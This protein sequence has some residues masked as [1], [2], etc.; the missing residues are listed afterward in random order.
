[1]LIAHGSSGH[2]EGTTQSAVAD[3]TV[4]VRDAANQQ[5]DVGTLSRDT[6][7][8]NGSIDPILTRKKSNGGCKRHS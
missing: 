2:A 7:H 4:I 5:Q 1:M 3:G 8:A 6:E